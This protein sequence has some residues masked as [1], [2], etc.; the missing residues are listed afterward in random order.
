MAKLTTAERKNLPSKAFV[1]PSTRRYPIHDANHARNA[2]ARASGKPEEAKVKAAVHKKFP[3][4]GKSD[5]KDRHGA[6]MGMWSK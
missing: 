4:I 3:N 5:K 2:L 1:F 6:L